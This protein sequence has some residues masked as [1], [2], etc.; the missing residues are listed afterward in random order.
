MSLYS[1]LLENDKVYIGADTRQGTWVDG[2]YKRLNDAA[3]KIICGKN[4]IATVGGSAWLGDYIRKSLETMRT[5]S[6]GQ[7]DDIKILL[8]IAQYGYGDHREILKQSLGTDAFNEIAAAVDNDPTQTMAELEVC[9]IRYNPTAK[10]NEFYALSSKRGMK[11]EKYTLKSIGGKRAFITGGF[12]NETARKSYD[13]LRTSYE[14]GFISAQELFQ[15]VYEDCAGRYVGGTLNFIEFK[16]GQIINRIETKIK[17]TAPPPTATMPNIFSA[18]NIIGE[19]LEVA[20]NSPDGMVQYFKFDVDGARFHNTGI[21]ITSDGP[22]EGNGITL[23]IGE[24]EGLIITRN[25][26]MFRAVM[27][28]NEGLYFQKAVT[29]F[30]WKDGNKTVTIDTNGSAVF[31]GDIHA[32]RLYLQEI[33]GENILA[34]IDGRGNR[35]Q[36]NFKDNSEIDPS[37]GELYGD[38]AANNE[39]NA[40]ISGNY[41]EGRGLKAYDNSGN[42]RVHINGADGSLKMYNGFIEMQNGN[43]NALYINPDD[44]IRWVIDGKDKFYF[45][46]KTNSLVFGGSIDTLEDIKIGRS[47]YMRCKNRQGNFEDEPTFYFLDESDNEAARINFSFGGS[48]APTLNIMSR[49]DIMLSSANGAVSVNFH[50]H[51]LE[52]YAPNGATL[53]G[54][55]IATQ[56]WVTQQLN[57][58]KESLTPQPPTII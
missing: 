2:E 42:L 18:H 51:Q 7:F 26:G 17:E 53:N 54:S 15:K 30:T 4:Y 47:L 22:G 32:K 12:K 5:L 56:E 45:D 33:G 20:C 21:R 9:A 10:E 57:A 19:T 55:S 16:D 1:F 48:E 52:I 3:D 13:K 40:K 39:P 36:V 37:T 24:N 27:N 41:L 34:Y 29:P 23:G 8:G 6:G 50:G 38:T 14:S 58:L 25:D 28:A 11:L 43:G 31:G 46:K 49:N 44:F 35:Y